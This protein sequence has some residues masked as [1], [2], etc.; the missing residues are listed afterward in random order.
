MKCAQQ[1]VFSLRALSWWTSI[2]AFVELSPAAAETVPTDVTQGRLLTAV[3]QVVKLAD[4]Y[5]VEDRFLGQIQA[6]RISQ[7]SFELSGT[8]VQVK[9]DEGDEVTS[10]QLL[11][12]LDT[13]RLEVGLRQERAG[14]A[15]AQSRLKLAD[16]T[17]DRTQ[18]LTPAKAVSERDLDQAV[19]EA[20]T[21][22]AATER[23][24]AAI[25]RINVD[26]AK[27]RITAPFAAR[28]SIRSVD[29]GSSVAG[30]QQILELMEIGVL[31]ARIGLTTE[32][33]RSIK[34]GSTVKL[35]TVD[36]QRPIAA[37]IKGVLP[38][39][40]RRTRTVGV[41]LSI[42][43]CSTLVPG[44]LVAWTLPHLVNESGVWLPRLALTSGAR[45]LWAAYVA[46]KD[47]GSKSVHRIERRELEVLHVEGERAFV[48]GALQTGDQVITD[49]LQR[50]VPGQRVKLGVDQTN[51]KNP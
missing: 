28:V 15:E 51:S 2:I 21:T 4:S 23:A 17:L 35:T 43:D 47:E 41:I 12:E 9:V 5:E 39:Q 7:M 1:Q 20:A 48:C 37:V 29:E 14:L 3:T 18:K 11:A 6:A 42:S 45:G 19:Q 46:V 26:L 27:S 34:I 49:G 30:G 13:S 24:Q 40:D 25:D 16:A 44:D 10:G 38:M 31:E 22:K 8:V 50:L 36:T 32:A 33:A